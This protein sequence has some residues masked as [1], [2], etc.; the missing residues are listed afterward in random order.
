MERKS[1]QVIVMTVINELQGCPHLRTFSPAVLA[2]L[3]LECGG[4]LGHRISGG[5]GKSVVKINIL[6]QYL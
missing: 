6:M 3:E 2:G 1:L 4:L 5:A